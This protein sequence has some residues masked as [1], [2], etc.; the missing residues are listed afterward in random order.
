LYQ[1]C[2]VWFR[3][4]APANR[5]QA[6]NNLIAKAIRDLETELAQLTLKEDKVK[7]VE[8]EK[9]QPHDPQAGSP[10]DEHQ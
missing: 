3:I 1:A 5:D 9:K 6:R 7:S 2:V 10:T 4:G 8:C